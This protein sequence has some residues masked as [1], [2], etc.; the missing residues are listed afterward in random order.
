[1]GQRVA[2]GQADLHLPNGWQLL[3]RPEDVFVARSSKG[4]QVTVSLLRFSSGIDFADFK[5]LGDKRLDIEKQ[6]FTEGFLAAKPAFVGGKT[7]NLFFFGEDK[8]KAR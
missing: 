7:F 2:I 6:G 1:M 5:R 4:E 3:K 8:Q